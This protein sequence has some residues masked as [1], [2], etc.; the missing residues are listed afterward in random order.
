MDPCVKAKGKRNYL[1]LKKK[2]EVIKTAEKNRSMS[3][4]EL[5]EQFN[6]GKTQVARF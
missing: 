5:S 6:C 2:V 4:R 1:T 3:V